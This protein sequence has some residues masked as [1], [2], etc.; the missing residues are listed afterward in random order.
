MQE[1]YLDFEKKQ[2]PELYNWLFHKG[3]DGNWAAIPR[4]K[5]ADYFNDYNTPGIIRSTQLSTVVELASKVSYDPEFLNTIE[6][7]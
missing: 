5:I 4:E 6:C 7:L 1:T 3:L 2:Q